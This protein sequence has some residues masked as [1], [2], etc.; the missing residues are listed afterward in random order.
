MR[1]AD[2]AATTAATI[3]TKETMCLERMFEPQERNE[4]FAAERQV[5]AGDEGAVAV[6]PEADAVRDVEVAEV[7]V[8]AFSGHLAGI[9]E[10][11]AV[12]RPPCFPA[13]L[14]GQQQAVGV[15]EA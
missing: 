11:R 8:F 2:A 12:Q 7:Q 10:E 15:L 14:G 6:E 9:D 3:A 4:A 1:G 5:E 13:V